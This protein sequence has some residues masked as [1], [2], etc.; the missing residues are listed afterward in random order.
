MRI[1]VSQQGKKLLI[2]FNYHPKTLLDKEGKKGRLV[3]D[4][5]IIDKSDGF[6]LTVDRFLKKNNI[7]RIGQIR[8]IEFINTGLLTERVI[9]A[10][11]RGLR[12]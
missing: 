1:T 4:K 7:S 10:I 3:V 12:F 9:R 8:H 5:Y 6:L 11:I 2:E